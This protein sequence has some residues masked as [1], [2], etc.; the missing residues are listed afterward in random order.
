MPASGMDS[1]VG[2]WE[3]SYRTSYTAL[4]SSNARSS[5]ADSR[6]STPA[7][8]AYPSQNASRLRSAH[9]TAR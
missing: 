2:R 5:T 1:Q 4:S 7:N 3:A 9:S 6:G 8:D